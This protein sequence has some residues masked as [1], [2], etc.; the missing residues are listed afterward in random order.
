MLTNEQFLLWRDYADSVFK[1]AMKK[2]IKMMQVPTD[3]PQGLHEAC[4][5]F[6]EAMRYPVSFLEWEKTCQQPAKK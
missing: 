1:N 5:E 4:E 3:D 2:H 6:Y